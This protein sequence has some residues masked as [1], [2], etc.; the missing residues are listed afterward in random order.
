MKHF[1]ISSVAILIAALFLSLSPTDGLGASKKKK[2]NNNS[3]RSR[4]SSVRSSSSSNPRMQVTTPNRSPI[5][6]S[7][8]KR[9]S[10]SSNRKP[11]SSN[12]SNNS[13]RSNSNAN[14]AR[15]NNNNATRKPSNS[16]NNN[17]PRPNNPG[18]ASKAKPNNPGNANKNKPNNNRPNNVVVR[19]PASNSSSNKAPSNPRMQV[20]RVS[21]KPGSVTYPKVVTVT[22]NRNNNNNRNHSNHNH[23]KHYTHK[24]PQ[25]VSTI[26]RN[27]SVVNRWDNSWRYSNSVWRSHSDYNAYNSRYYR[28]RPISSNFQHAVN[29]AYRPTAWGSRPWW[30]SGSCHDWHRGSW[31]YGWNNNWRSRH[32]RPRPYY[33]PGYYHSDSGVGTALAWGLAGWTLGKLVYDTGYS[34]YRNPYSAPPIQHYSGGYSY[35]EPITVYAADEAPVSEEVAETDE[36]KSADALDASR[37][38]FKQGDY[39]SALSKADEAI[40]YQTGDPALHEYRALTLFAL[41]RYGDAAGVLNPVLASGPGWDWATMIGLYPSSDV[42]TGQL[43]KLEN[44]VSGNPDSADAHFVLGYHYMVGG[45]LDEAYQMFDRVTQLQPADS[46]ARQLRDLAANS[47][48]SSEEDAE[49]VAPATP[50]SEPVFIPEEQLYGNWKALSGDGKAIHL[51]LTEEG[52]FSW[53]YEGAADDEVL[54]GDWSIDD[55]GNLVLADEDVQLVGEISLEGENTLRFVLV[56]G[57]EGDPGLTFERL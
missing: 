36:A 48:P 20:N 24:Q 57:P 13:N 50:D 14:K 32:Y 33:P 38:A 39:L 55:D 37:A 16:G 40:S 34:T 10:S 51:V 45:F 18:S 6:G 19:K 8:I 29:Y 3:N 23:G 47:L 35:S 30:D 11:S 21:P 7:S 15:P 54:S 27:T 42:Y 25:R 49:P 22:G 4:Q 56:G 44:Y 41:G 31:N 5:T 12:R 9:S 46:V 52:G 26:V 1:T 43:R 17:K 53:K 28:P 2:N